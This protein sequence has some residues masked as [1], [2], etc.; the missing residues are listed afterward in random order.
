MNFILAFLVGGLI[1]LIGQFLLDKFKLLPLHI[2]VIFVIV[3]ASLEL[4]DIYDKLVEFASAGALVP[5]SSFGHSLAHSAY[6]GAKEEGFIGLFTNLF[7][8]TSGGISVAV[9]AG[10]FCSLI[11][12][13][14]S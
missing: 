4:F 8:L 14:K 9:L 2:T 3:G 1:C 10:F 13:V 5:I 12:K 6:L 7:N 11:F